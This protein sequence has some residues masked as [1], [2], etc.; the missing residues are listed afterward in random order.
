M[1]LSKA[2]KDKV[3][4]QFASNSASTN[5]YDTRLGGKIVSVDDRLTGSKQ[6][7]LIREYRAPND[8]LGYR[9]RPIIAKVW[10]YKVRKEVEK[11][12]GYRRWLSGH[13]EGVTVGKEGEVEVRATKGYTRRRT[14][15]MFL[16]PS[17]HATLKS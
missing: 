12:L 7:C 13:I 8:C 15:L 11:K 10:S 5:H 17:L 6:T 14:D 16:N 3:L 2:D 1:D 4:E 9:S